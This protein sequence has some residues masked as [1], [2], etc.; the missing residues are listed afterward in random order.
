MALSCNSLSSHGRLHERMGRGCELQLLAHA[1]WRA[2]QQRFHI[3]LLE[4]KA[5]RFSVES[6]LEELRGSDST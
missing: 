6:F 1:F 4:L 5:V 3:T 2:A